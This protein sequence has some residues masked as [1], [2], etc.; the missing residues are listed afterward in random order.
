[1][2][3]SLVAR[4]SISRARAATVA[5]TSNPGSVTVHA[6]RRGPQHGRQSWATWCERR[7]DLRV[8]DDAQRAKLRSRSNGEAAALSLSLIGTG[9]AANRHLSRGSGWQGELVSA[10]NDMQASE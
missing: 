1:M 6:R 3:S 9:S 7:A 8:G 5:G 10:V 4:T 2:S